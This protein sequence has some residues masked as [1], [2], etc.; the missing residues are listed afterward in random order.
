M[1]STKLTGAAAYFDVGAIQDSVTATPTGCSTAFSTAFFG[2]AQGNTTRVVSGCPRLVN[3]FNMVQLLGIAEFK[4]GTQ[5][6]V[7]FADYLQNQEADDLDTA[8]SLGLTYG[9]ASAPMSW[10]FGYAYQVVEKDAQFGQFVDS[11]FG[12]GITDTAGSVLRVG[13]APLS[14]WTLNGTYFMN[15]RFVDVG[16][17]R[18]Y[19]RWQIDMNYKF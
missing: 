2:G 14:G 12:G 10:E 8:Y 1:G 7:L 13:F 19:K 15:K 16:T 11:D 18:D 17:E 3:D 4:L 6:L 9:R 5:P